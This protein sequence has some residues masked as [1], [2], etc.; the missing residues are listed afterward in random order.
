MKIKQKKCPGISTETF[1]SIL[2]FGD[3]YSADVSAFLAALPNPVEDLE[4]LDLLTVPFKSSDKSL[5]IGV[6][7]KIDEYVPTKIPINNANANPLMVDPPNTS[8]I[9][10]T[11]NVV[12]D[13]TTVLEK[14]LFNA[15]S[16][17]SSFSLLVYIPRY[18]LILSNTTTVSLI[19]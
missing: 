6:A 1:S 15:E 2:L 4:L 10:T 11:I 18:S 5:T 12:N 9:A 17:I 3:D 14:V 7:T 8:N 13:V 16:N 19:E